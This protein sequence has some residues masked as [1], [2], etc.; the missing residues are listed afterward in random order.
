[1]DARETDGRGCGRLLWTALVI[2]LG[3]IT[4]A[5]VATTSKGHGQAEHYYF[6]TLTTDPAKAGQEHDRGIEVAQLNLRWD[7]YEPAPGVYDRDYLAEL[8]RTLRT[9]HRAGSRIEVGLGLNHP[10]GWL[11][12]RFPDAAYVDQYGNRYTG[13]ANIVFS[14]AVR[15]EA[16][17]YLA[18]VQRDIGLGTFWA[19]RVGVDAEGEFLYPPA[20]TGGG[21]INYWAFDSNAQGG[22]ADPGRPATILPDPFPG[23]RPGSHEYR[24]R[25]FSTAEV[26]QWYH[27][28]LGSLADAVDWQIGF[29]RSLGYQGYLKVL[30]P[31]SGYYPASLQEAIGH[32]LQG[33]TTP[34]LLGSG[35]GFFKT[36]AL[37]KQRAGVVITS[38]SLVDGSGTPRNNGCARSDLK[39]DILALP[40][41]PVIYSWSSVR[42]IANI[43]VRDG[44]TRLSGESAGAQ[45]ADYYPGV[46]DDAARQMSSCGLR[47]LMWAFDESLYDGTP[48]SSLA[49]YASVVRRYRQAPVDGLG[50][51]AGQ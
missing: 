9:L 23:W 3:L 40:A 10:P 50:A 48:G 39:V 17:A 29:Y 14:A 43:A 4:A 5:L 38:T 47:G 36:L 13:T 42:W 15:G 37:I 22:A 11:F 46:M 8:S 16:Q 18:R 1:M 25:A 12:D 41:D 2:V 31:G 26:A 24:G 19:I 45:V 35:A 7:L 33:A 51:L 6:G 21:S 20:N 27:W 49:D 28:Y 32:F 44:F 30:V 34:G